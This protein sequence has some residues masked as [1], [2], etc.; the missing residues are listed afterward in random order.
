ML[1]PSSPQY[2]Q[3]QSSAPVPPPP[4]RIAAPPQSLVRDP[5]IQPMGHRPGSSMSI[6]SMLGT[7]PDSS[8][9]DAI[10]PHSNGPLKGI[11]PPP[12]SPTRSIPQGSVN[13]GTSQRSDTPETYKSWN[14][15]HTRQSR[16]YS[17]GPPQR[18]YS[19]FQP[20]SPESS[21]FGVSSQTPLSQHSSS[22]Y[23]SLQDGQLQRNES[24][25]SRR[26]TS[27]GS[28]GTPISSRPSILNQPSLDSNLVR[29]N[30]HT[31]YLSEPAVTSERRFPHQGQTDSPEGRNP[32]HYTSPERVHA[33]SHAPRSAKPAQPQQPQYGARDGSAGV[34]TSSNYPFLS[35]QPPQ[36]SSMDRRYPSSGDKVHQD[37]N[38]RAAFSSP[39]NH[40]QTV[41]GSHQMRPT[42]MTESQ[43]LR[44]DLSQPLTPNT[45]TSE[46]Q[47]AR[48]S[49]LLFTSRNSLATPS[50]DV[51]VHSVED[52]NQSS[53]LLGFLAE[54]KRGRIS[55]LPQAVQGVQGKMKGPTS[56][57]G[58]KKEF[59]MM[60]SGIGSGVG[61][62]MST[63]VPPDS[64]APDSIPSSP[65]RF[66]EVERRTPL[67]PKADLQDAK[68]SRNPKKRSRKTRDNDIKREE[69]DT[70]AAP[71]LLRSLSGMSGRGQKKS[72]QSYQPTSTPVHQS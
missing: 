22:S 33:Y 50:S 60:F 15:E 39:L 18:P 27:V 6:S 66:E 72:R 68:K 67:G 41:M 52:G 58:I 59:G 31:P 40:D 7:D 56:E 71:N 49:P 21:R 14:P 44:Q 37:Q 2:A 9:R 23:Q 4:S 63:P 57:P 12:R 36:S 19:G 25:T 69:L 42:V 28:L 10:R 51:I 70:R 38:S 62:N 8:S 48:D 20:S 43:A 13:Q 32:D 61:S 45:D 34:S 16:A 54:T 11:P 53:R 47:R 1:P 24:D 26:R 55:P 17:G 3:S 30:N 29:E 35:R 65:T 46:R 5:V 64:Q